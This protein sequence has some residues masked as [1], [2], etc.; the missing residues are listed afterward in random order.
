MKQVFYN[1]QPT[2]ANNFARF[3]ATFSKK[4]KRQ[5]HRDWNIQSDDL[6]TTQYDPLKMRN[7]T[8]DRVHKTQNCFRINKKN[9][10]HKH[11]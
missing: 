10:S 2:L 6:Q 4:E 11:L 3:S 8:A 7:I 9:T 5:K 1:V